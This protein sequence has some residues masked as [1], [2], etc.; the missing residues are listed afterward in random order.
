MNGTVSFYRSLAPATPSC[1][2]SSY[3]QSIFLTSGN[4]VDE[5]GR[6]D[7]KRVLVTAGVPLVLSNGVSAATA[8]RV[9]AGAL[10]AAI[11]D[12]EFLSVIRQ[13]I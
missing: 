10:Q 9:V 1:Y 5:A 4:F 13:E 2:L 11:S 8:H 6:P 12:R 7:V 3:P